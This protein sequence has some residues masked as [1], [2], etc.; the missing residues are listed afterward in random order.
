MEIENDP[1]GPVL[2][3][4]S[5]GS[6]LV[7]VGWKDGRSQLYRRDLGQFDAMPIPGTEDGRQPFFSTDGRWVAFFANGELKKV[8]LAGG[9]TQIIAEAPKP[10]GASWGPDGTIVFN[11]R[12]GEGLCRVSAVGGAPDV[13]LARGGSWNYWP[14]FLPDVRS[15]LFTNFSGLI[16]DNPQIQIIDL[17]SRA[18][19][20]VI[21]D[22]SYARYVPTG[23]LVF[24]HRAGIRA[25]PFDAD[26]REINGPAVPIPEP[27]LYDFEN[28][29]PQLAIS[30]TGSLAFLR[31]GST[32]RRQL[33]SV[34]L[35]ARETPLIEAE[36]GFAYPRYSPDGERL[37]FTI[38]EPGN[39]NIWILNL[40]TRA[41]SK[42]TL[43]GNN[44]FPVWTPDG[45]RVTFH[46]RRRGVDGIYWKRAD[47][48]GDSEPLVRTE[49]V[50]DTMVPHSWSPDGNTLVFQSLSS[51]EAEVRSDLW[52]MTLEGDRNPRPLMAT[53]ALE[54]GA[55]LSPDGRW[56]A[57]KSNESG[58]YEIY[59]QPFP[60]GGERHQ[61]STD[62]AL[63]A[64]WSTD[65]RAIFFQTEDQVLAVPVSTV[66]TFRA[67]AP[68]V[69]FEAAYDP[70]YSGTH[71]NF[72]IAP[73]G[74]SFVF[75]K[76]DEEWGRATEIRMVLNWFEELK[77]LAPTD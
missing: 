67:G 32:P 3:I 51:T 19:K 44:N 20:T 56:L 30:T 7:F 62:G 58:R 70:G 63:P 22:G 9:P 25:V 43:E 2:A 48:S 75:V 52:I 37:A 13:F 4:S 29:L 14:E 33:V 54:A 5:D 59:V 64:V 36:G 71:R 31:G 66:P 11:R 6:W 72:D 27:I 24:G 55:A 49:K 73:D 12:L 61:L 34:D 69:L 53:A 65:G 76:A 10:C 15:V 39:V 38:S 50:G 17:E 47:G 60:G 42:L 46:S 1:L 74:K 57:Y 68:R 77:R 8:P 16:D 28:G 23:H 35:E 45:E 26:R 41:Q 40:S 21:E 18:R